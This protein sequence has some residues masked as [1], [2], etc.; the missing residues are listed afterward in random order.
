MIYYDRNGTEI[1]SS[2]TPTFRESVHVMLHDYDRIVFINPSYTS[3]VWELPGGGLE[4][5]E[6]IPEALN[7]ECLE[8]IGENITLDKDFIQDSHTQIINFYADDCDE[9]LSVNNKVANK[10]I[11]LFT[12]TISQYTSEKQSVHHLL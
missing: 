11:E 1:E 4:L 12:N 5:N 8:E 7:R 10:T 9:F 3:N 6:S 2:V